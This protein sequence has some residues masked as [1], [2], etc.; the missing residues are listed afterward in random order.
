MR[1][2]SNRRAPAR[3]RRPR[4]EERPR[5][6]AI[7]WVAAVLIIGGTFC[8]DSGVRLGGTGV[9][10][11]RPAMQWK[12]GSLP[13]AAF[14]RVAIT[15]PLAGE[16]IAID[17]GHNGRNWAAPSLVTQPI[18]NGREY[19]PCDTS[20]SETGS[21]YTEARFNFSLARYL[22]ADLGAEGATV[23]L[24]RLSNSG[25]GPCVNERAAIANNARANAAISIHADGGPPTG[26]GFFVLEPVAD[27]LN[28]AVIGPSEALA[29]DIRNSFLAYTGEP[30]SNYFGINGIEP[31]ND[32]AALNLTTVPKVLVECANMRNPTDAA[33]ITANVWQLNAAK[34]LSAGLAEFLG[35]SGGMAL[36]RPSTA[37][38]PHQ[39][40]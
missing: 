18:W 37:R 22:A 13:S 35:R 21:G 36:T 31:S 32:L 26:R 29:L 11:K 30:V 10:I 38:A 33:L 25:V 15:E 12:L 7:V 16:V 40:P 23:V 4:S 34:G 28:S 5:S 9:L 39:R 19:E 3:E 6:R 27:G 14:A 2:R 1:N 17:P 8:P 20:G 24:T